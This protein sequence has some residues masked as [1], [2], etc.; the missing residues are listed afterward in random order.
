MQRTELTEIQEQWFHRLAELGKD[1]TSA[2]SRKRNLKEA[3][4]QQ[5]DSRA[6]ALEALSTSARYADAKADLSS[7]CMEIQAVS[8]M[9]QA[10][11]LRIGQPEVNSVE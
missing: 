10:L 7:A 9:I 6:Q 1:Y 8:A 4:I 2:V 11:E 5:T 3:A